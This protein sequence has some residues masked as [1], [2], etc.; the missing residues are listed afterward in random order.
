[1]FLASCLGIVL[2][3]MIINS[4]EISITYDWII[5]IV[6]V[7]SGIV[8][9]IGLKDIFKRNFQ[10]GGYFIVIGWTVSLLCMLLTY[11]EGKESQENYKLY[12]ECPYC[13][14]NIYEGATVCQYCHRDM[15]PEIGNTWK[16]PKCDERNPNNTYQCLKCGYHL[17]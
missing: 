5:T 4:K 1:M 16:C 3:F 17:V 7:G 2:L 13:K 8:A 9:F 12:K 11:F 15:P 14:N 10:T 6:T